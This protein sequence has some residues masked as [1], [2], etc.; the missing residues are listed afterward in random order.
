LVEA[1][2]GLPARSCATAKDLQVNGLDTP[3]GSL[4]IGRRE[5]ADTAV[6]LE[7]NED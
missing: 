4:R 3:M 5:K 2:T 6:C 1:L 7:V